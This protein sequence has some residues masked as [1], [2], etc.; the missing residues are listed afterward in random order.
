MKTPSSQLKLC[1]LHLRIID[2]GG[3]MLVDVCLSEER[4]ITFGSD[5]GVDYEVVGDGVLPVHL[6]V[7]LE[8]GAVWVE[9]ADG[10][11]AALDGEPL[12][13]RVLA[14]PRFALDLGT[15]RIEA[16][17]ETPARG[18]QAP[19]ALIGTVLSGYRLDKL[20]GEGPVSAVFRATQVKLDRQVVLKVLS[21]QRTSGTGKTRRFL[22]M[23]ELSARLSHPNLV[24]VYDSG[25]DAAR[26]LHFKVMESL[27]D[28][29]TLAQVLAEQGRLAPDVLLPILVQVAAALEHLHER[30]IV[31]RNLHPANVMVLPSQRI[32]LAG[33]SQLA[34]EAS[35]AP[36]VLDSLEQAV[37]LAPE[38]FKGKG[39]ARSDLYSLGAIGYRALSGEL[40]TAWPSPAAHFA[41]LGRG[42]PIPPLGRKAR[43]SADELVALIERAMHPDPEQRY[44]N[45]SALKGDLRALTTPEGSNEQTLARMRSHLSAMLPSSPQVPGFQSA[46]LYRPA[47][48]VGGDFYDVFACSN[49]DEWGL[50]VGDVTG[51]GM[52]A[53]SIAGMAKMAIRILARRTQ[54]PRNALLLAHRELSGDLARNTFVSAILLLIS[55]TTRLVRYARAGQNPPILYNPQRDPPIQILQAPGMA[56][57]MIKHGDLPLEERQLQLVPGD[58]LLVLTDGIVETPDATGQQFGLERLVSFVRTNYHLAPQQMALELAGVLEQYSIGDREAAVQEDDWTVL[59]LKFCD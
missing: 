18:I 35:E 13:G 52:E 59:F 10:A 23:V 50:V 31:H 44:P 16:E 38:Q 30:G 56:L 28:A 5:V 15:A 42:E 53:M 40:P 20:L 33:L 22:Q 21:P 11:V 24:R 51:H 58:L 7:G 9:C 12:K 17:L 26:E 19:S 57:G 43:G 2:D 29:R 4:P 47:Q 27:D 39:E 45:A 32:K 25:Y 1:Q 8:G 36:D 46:V 49:T 41:A 3:M 54:G 6:R 55:P 14:P 48:G 34:I 37:Y